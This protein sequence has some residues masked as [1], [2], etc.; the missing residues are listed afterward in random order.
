MAVKINLKQVEAFVT[1]ADIRSFRR[2]AEALNTTQPNISSRISTLET[3]IGASLMD[4]DAG[5]V[6]LTPKGEALLPFARRALQSMDE[7]AVAAAND[8]LFE[9]TIRIGATE[10]V[11]HTWLGAFLKSLK[12]K[13]TDIHVELTVDVSANLSELLFSKSLDLALQSG[14]FDRRAQGEVELGDCPLTWVASPGLGVGEGVLTLKDLTSLPILAHA[15]GT[16]PYTQ[17]KQHLAE[18]G[19]SNVELSSSTNLAACLQM[20]LEGF[21]VACLPQPMVMEAIAEGKLQRL[22]YLWRPD[23]LNFRARYDVKKASAVVTQAA[24]TAA[25][26]AEKIFDQ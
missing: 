7:F 2:A 20:T 17:F 26:A 23:A 10:I 21:G 18:N 4:R 1:V 13:F 19:A 15:R 22:R 16:L 3:L 25:I 14:P 24:L 9:G 12:E 5:S 8:A 11:A 6:R